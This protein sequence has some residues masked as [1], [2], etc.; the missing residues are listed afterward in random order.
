MRRIGRS[1]T[2]A[3]TGHDGSAIR[4]SSTCPA[5]RQC[6]EAV[7]RLVDLNQ[8]TKVVSFAAR[9]RSA[10]PRLQAQSGTLA[11]PRRAWPRVPSW[12]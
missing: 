10:A 12:H 5:C 2:V 9:A 4:A 8:E 1:H 11:E 6:G 7:V 3:R